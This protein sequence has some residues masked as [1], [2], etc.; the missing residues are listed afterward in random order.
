MK[1]L[2]QKGKKITQRRGEA[3]RSAEIFGGESDWLFGVG[4]RI[5]RGNERKNRTLEK[6]K[7]AAPNFR[8]I[9]EL[10]R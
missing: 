4:G 7:G 10:F 1:M 9:T 2:Q 8:G 3:Q 5:E 6:H